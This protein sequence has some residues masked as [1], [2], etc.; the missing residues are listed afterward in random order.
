MASRAVALIPAA[1]SLLIV[2]LTL[3]SA[4]VAALWGGGGGLGPADWAALRFTL[5][6]AALS[7][8]VSALLAV[9]LARALVR[10]RFAG[11][12]LLLRLMAA[13]FLLPVVVA[14]LGLLAVFGR[15]GPVNSLLAVL[16]L[17][18]LS[19]FGLHGVV[20]AHVFLNLP[21]VTRILVHGWQ[22]IP[23]E[24]FR[25][26]Q[27]LGM[28][29]GPQFRHL[30]L[31]MLRATLPGAAA[32][33]FLLCLT[34][35]AVAL[36]LG[37][38]PKAST[39]ELAIYQALRFD[40]LPGKAA[41]LA[42][43]QFALCAAVTLVAMRL[44]RVEGFGAG[45]GRE[46]EIAAPGGWRWSLDALVIVL[47]AGFL[48]APL[49]AVAWRGAPG[50]LALPAS[51]G[52][53][54]A[55]SLIVAVLSAGLAAG[56]ALVLVQARV[57]GRRWAELAAMLPLAAS[58]LVMGTGLFLVAQP[59]MP[60]EKLA[61]PVTMLVNATLALPYLFRLLLPEA[62]RL[63]ADYA[64]LAESLS[65]RGTAR[66]RLLLLPRLA[67]PLGFGTGLAAALS[68]GDLGVIALFAGERGVTLPLL[69]QRLTGAYRMEAAAAAALL[70]VGL[71]FAL[72]WLFD[73]WGA[74]HA[75]A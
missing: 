32:L 30:E 62:L 40:F 68:M 16:G 29:P 42:A 33:V 3:G 22:A 34:S 69:V 39:V 13:P 36:T 66:L 59:L 24:R 9:P 27:A 7:A 53:A 12:G 19:V 50:L 11:R 35:F 67:R 15:T 21:L 55:R 23:A 72:F 47:S 71:S 2:A 17:P 48:L 75:A 74:R 65:L 43:V 49:L 60:V 61:L 57:A 38:G 28:G 51:V 63:Q 41:T 6:Q 20:L 73:R 56:A 10:R 26:A 31:P 44:A 52:W 18:A 37:G 14:V 45:L 5:L 8:V 4:A 64:R 70:L 25:L 58:G 1:L 46:V 54:A